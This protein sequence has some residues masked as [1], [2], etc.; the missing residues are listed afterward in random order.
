MTLVAVRV[1]PEFAEILTDTLATGP[2]QTTMVR[3]SKV[4]T[5][6]HLNAAI[7]GR[8]AAE[9]TGNFVGWLAMHP[10]IAGSFD[11]LDEL[12][13]DHLPGMWERV[14][15]KDSRPL[16][17]Q[18][19]V[20]W[21]ESRGRFVAREYLSSDDFAGSDVT[22]VGFFCHPDMTP[23]LLPPPPGS[24]QDWVDLA[25]TVYTVATAAPQLSG[26]CCLIGGDILLTRLERGSITQRV[27]H[28]LSEDDWRF[29][30][31]VIGGL[32][33][34]GQ[35]GPCMC[36]S[37]QPYIVCCLRPFVDEPCDCGSE[38]P[39]RDCHLLDLDGDDLP[40]VLEF[41]AQHADEFTSTRAELRAVWEA[42]TPADVRATYAQVPPPPVIIRHPAS[43]AV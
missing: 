31:G 43:Q 33:W 5:F 16:A 8:G 37:G 17:R 34:Q 23:R 25:E 35:A 38:R 41:W 15:G 39:L 3:S 11:A 24:T 19:H 26:R 7:L 21:S 30:R 10:D 13:R 42:T 36:G 4:T 9:L 14:E 22:E 6:P 32:H 20:G 27:I 28:H 40:R 1:E 2:S 12:A 29:R 18:L